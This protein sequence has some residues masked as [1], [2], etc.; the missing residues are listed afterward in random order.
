MQQPFIVSAAQ[1][2][3]VLNPAVPEMLCNLLPMAKPFQL[4][5]Q[6]LYAVPHDVDVVRLLRNVGVQV[7]SPILHQYQW[8]GKYAPFEAQRE[9]AAFLTL[10]PRAFVLNDMGTGKTMAT[11]WAYDFLRGIGK[12]Q[13]MLVVAPLST[14]ERT[15]GDTVFANFPHLSFAV[16]HGSKDRRLKLLK[17]PHDVYIVN[18]DG[19]EVIAPALYEEVKSG[20]KVTGVRNLRPDIDVI[21]IDE[22]AVLRNSATDR[23][24][25]TE[26]ICQEPDRI[27]W[28]LTGTPIPNEPTDAWAQI[29][30]VDATRVPKY[31]GRFRD[32]T[33]NKINQ[34]K[35]VARK[36]ALETVQKHM[37]PAIRY[38]REDCVDLPETL[39][40]TRHIPLTAQ[41]KQ[42][43]E[44][45][46][47]RMKAEEE[48][49]TVRAVNEADKLMKLVQVAAGAVYTTDGDIVDIDNNGRLRELLE[50]IEQAQGKVIV[51]VPFIAALKNLH[52]EVS[53]HYPTE[54]VYGGTS[55]N[56]RDTAFWRFTNLPSTESRVLLANA[57]AMSHGLTLVEANTIVWWAPHTSHETFDQ[58]NHRIIRPGQK[59]NT[60]I[61]MMEGSEVER[62]IYARLQQRQA[63]QGLLL[64]AIRSAVSD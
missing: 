23:Y 32:M 48:A 64:D 26:K 60:F 7:P 62:K 36:D 11:M 42:V 21:V 27:V 9:T 50:I 41:Q 46:R 8:K 63:T 13:R 58:A 5:G 53:K 40:Q 3:I 25:V 39:Y 54:L 18:H 19:L 1:K 59:L 24:K 51:F 28:G 56:D 33:M 47:L 38:S 29:K 16:L 15:W 34:F 31:F 2:A 6:T 61:I 57:A 20:K 4:H 49:G 35:Y 14:L 44:D 22:I 30:L 37:Q 10:N 52:A 45:I 12:R 43:Y 17:Q 55:K